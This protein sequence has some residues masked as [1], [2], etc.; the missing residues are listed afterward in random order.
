MR[1]RGFLKKTKDLGFGNAVYLQRNKNRKKAKSMFKKLMGSS[2]GIEKMIKELDKDSV[3]DGQSYNDRFNNAK[4]DINEKIEEY[5]DTA[6]DKELIENEIEETVKAIST[7][8]KERRQLLGKIP[9]PHHILKGA[10]WRTILRGTKKGKEYLN[11]NEKIK[12]Q[13][14]VLLILNE[15]YDEILIDFHESSKSLE[16]SRKKLEDLKKEIKREYKALKSKNKNKDKE[17]EENEKDEGEKRNDKSEEE[18]KEEIAR[19]ISDERQRRFIEGIKKDAGSKK[20][21]SLLSSVHGDDRGEN[22][23]KQKEDL[24]RNLVNI[25]GDNVI[26]EEMKE[27]NFAARDVILLMGYYNKASLNGIKIGKEDLLNA[28]MFNGPVYNYY[29]RGLQLYRDNYLYLQGT[30]RDGDKEK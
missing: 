6:G 4:E 27:Q 2:K 5:E 12:E 19:Y 29:E 18:L 28:R 20:D 7:Y 30:K 21:E 24:Y 13:R 8:R 26:S 11:V 14:E 22:K 15:N 10:L 1:E 3:G 25:W 23:G 16:E 9:F 17:N